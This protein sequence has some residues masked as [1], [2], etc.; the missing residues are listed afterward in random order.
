MVFTLKQNLL[1]FSIFL[2]FIELIFYLKIKYS[3]KFC[4][5]DNPVLLQLKTFFGYLIPF[6][7]FVYVLIYALLLMGSFYYLPIIFIVIF[8]QIVSLITDVYV[9]LLLTNS[10]K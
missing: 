1:L 7:E 8:I 10:S 9:Y 2:L 3:I 6:Y 5:S 4:E